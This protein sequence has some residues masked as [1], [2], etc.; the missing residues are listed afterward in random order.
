[1]QNHGVVIVGKTLQEAY[2]KF[3][4]LEYLA[5]SLVS[6]IPLGMPIPLSDD[7]LDDVSSSRALYR[8]RKRSRDEHG[9]AVTTHSILPTPV[10]ICPSSNCCCPKRIISGIEKEA[11]ATLC[12]FV[13][14]AYDQSLVT[15][16]SG[17]FSERIQPRG[18]KEYTHLAVSFLVTPTG[19]D[20][21]SLSCADL[22]FVSNV[23]RC[24]CDNPNHKN[25]N[26]PS[27]SSS[28]LAYHP[29][30][31]QQ[32]ITPSRASALHASIYASH[33]NINCI[34]IATPPNATA[35]C[36][37]GMPFNAAGIPESHLVLRDVQALPLSAVLEDNG[38]AVAR[39]LDPQ[40]GKHTVL[41]QNYGLLSIGSDFL[42]TFVQV[43]VCESMCG[44]MLTA[45]RRGTPKLL[46][47]EEVQNIDHEF[48]IGH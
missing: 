25:T 33:P 26:A 5:R 12:K 35:Y 34:I 41:I 48:K 4:S 45:M 31:S 10:P 43:E 13:K 36:I 20:R 39:A 46:S 40:N 22:C 47:R 15:S 14:R 32:D 8:A 27:P 16:T 1:M 3:V 29:T 21:C 42:K 2:D 9:N 28:L 44:V 24:S 7:I 23:Q 37:T 19:V 30:P 38:L 18:Q 6:A 17:S 11:R